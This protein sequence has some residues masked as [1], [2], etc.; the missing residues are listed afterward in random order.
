MK[1]SRPKLKFLQLPHSVAARLKSISNKTAADLLLLLCEKT[2]GFGRGF[3][4]LSYTQISTFLDVGTRAI[5]NAAKILEQHGHIRRER[6]AC[7]IYRWRIVLQEKDILHDPSSTYLTKKEVMIDQSSPCST[8]DHDH[9]DCPIMTSSPPFEHSEPGFIGL[10]ETS[11]EHSDPA[12]KILIKDKDLK[13]QHQTPHSSKG[14][15]MSPPVAKLCDDEPLHKILLRDLRK[16]G[17]SSRVA[18]ELCRDHDHSLITRVLS[19]APQRPGIKNLAAY[20]VSEIKDG[21]YSASSASR[22]Q[23]STS[24]VHSKPSEQA[25]VTYRT[26]KQTQKDQEALEQERLKRE[27]SY[28]NQG[29]LLHKRFQS[30][31]EEIQLRLKLLA[32]LQLARELPQTG[33]REQ[34]LKDKTFQRLANRQ[35]L[36]QF[37]GW[38]DKGLDT[39]QAL[40]RLENSLQLA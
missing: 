21:G 4:D 18:R 10:K 33:N 36:D 9:G 17:V 16:H 5:S 15:R 11:F 14:N 38:I 40:S 13:K 24:T 30:L 12:L 34:M 35:T 23:N 1:T 37:F 8:I 26:P 32:S 7:R 25:P 22:T 27:Q 28:Q 3:V 19:T 6:A 20:I 2:V 39:L 31:T 29:R